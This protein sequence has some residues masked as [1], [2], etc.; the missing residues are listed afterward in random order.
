LEAQ[1]IFQRI[2]NRD[3]Y[4][5]V[6]YKVFDWEHREFLQENITPEDIVAEAK[7]ECF[8]RAAGGQP[9]AGSDVETNDESDDISPEDIEDLT[10]EK[11]IVSFSTMHYGMKEKNPLDFVK[12][13][14]KRRPNGMQ[15][16]IRIVSNTV[17]NQYLECRHVRRGDLSLLM[18]QQFAEVLLRVYTKD[19]RY[20][21]NLS[22]CLGI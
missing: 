2:Q 21:H 6:E 14:T 5:C 22:D 4:R 17:S 20:A 9:V 16:C 11:V 15:Y 12:F 19:V 3:L 7:R 13:Y 18:P 10:K 8:A 1:S